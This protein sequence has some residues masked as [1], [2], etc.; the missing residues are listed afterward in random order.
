MQ[1]H[2]F[3]IEIGGTKLQIVV[4]DDAQAIVERHRF[5]VDRVR[6]AD[7]IRAE[8]ETALPSLVEKWR[9]AA[10]GVGFG[11]PV[12]RTTGQIACSHQ[13]E[14]WSEF[15]LG[16]WLRRV[17][18]IPVSV[19]NDANTAAL[20]EAMRGAGAG[21]NPIFYVTL[22]SGVGGGGVVDGKIYHGAPPGESEIG[23]VRLDKS[24][25][26]V[27]QRCSGWAVDAKIRQLKADGAKSL[28][29]DW[30]PETPGGEA[31][32]LGRALAANDA[33]ARRIL[34]ETAED[35]AFALSHVTHLFHPEVIVLGGGLSLVGEPLRIAVAQALP[36]FVMEVFRGR[37]SVNLAALGEDAVPVGAL[38]L[39]SRGR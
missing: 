31:K 39:A 22:G 4:G 8:V 23:H 35:L 26:I 32:F 24:G 38:L 27:E 12:D 10:I 20:G 1:T 36:R 3:G 19:E 21:F 34:E 17:A 30:L 33:A 15:Q 29:C 11:G 28:L 6:G 9:P 37:L 2:F 18:E 14:G 16:E 13:I 25:V 7:G 5:T